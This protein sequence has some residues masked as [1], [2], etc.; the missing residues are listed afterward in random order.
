MS[1]IVRAN[2]QTVQRTG[3]DAVYGSGLDGNGY[4]NATTTIT[5]DMYYNDLEITSSGILLTNGYRVFVK[6]TLTLNGHI[7]MG[8][9]SSGT[10]GEP[11]SDISDGTVA[12]NTTSAITYRLGGQGGGGSNPGITALPAFLY[13]NIDAM[14]GGVFADPTNGFIKIGGGSKGST[15][16]TGTTTPALTAS[17]NWPGKAGAA[18]T[19]GPAGSPNRLLAGQPG[20]KGSTASA[21]NADG[22]P[23]PGGAGG[24]GGAG[25]GIVAIFAK[26][27][28][29]SG[30]IISIGR[31]GSAGSAGT[32]GS[33]GTTGANGA[34]A[35]D[36]AYHVAPTTHSNAPA[37]NH[38]HHNHFTNHSDR[39][40]HVTRAH[41]H[42]QEHVRTSCPA[43]C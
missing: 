11:A 17:D 36:L 42:A 22:T 24:I 15:G 7:G 5:S 2:K 28:V 40:G 34:K 25:G 32:S 1:G 30:K 23:G 37:R 16:T 43:A 9:V 29:G 8:S 31:S 4:I 26:N 3:N 35:P 33:A 13:K 27:I 21:G 38:N 10:V 39:H 41:A 19:D 20:G 12:G 18:G 14:T 6:G